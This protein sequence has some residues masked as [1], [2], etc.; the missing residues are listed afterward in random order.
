M[1]GLIVG[2]ILGIFVGIAVALGAHVN[3]DYSSDTGY[4]FSWDSTSGPASLA[5][6]ALGVL[7][8][9]VARR[10][11]DRRL[12]TSAGLLDVAN[13]QPV[14]IGSFF[15]PRNVGCGRDRE[16]DR[17]RAD[18]DRVALCFLPG[19]VVALFT[20][21]TTIVLIDRNLS[22]IDAIKAS[23]DIVK[24]NIG[25]SILAYLIAGLIT[26]VGSSGVRHRN[27][28]R[29]AG[30]GAVPGVHLP[31]AQWRPGR[32]AHALNNRFT[33]GGQAEWTMTSPLRLQQR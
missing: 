1:Y 10:R 21:F 20:M 17:G 32:T 22:P 5:V 8:L 9:I 26:F 4:S 6:S 3:Y 31:Q 27:L 15:K 14:T 11:R 12:H 30:G 24:A 23:I 7:V 28:R 33:L 18:V 13:G 25:Q 19:L 29:A 16:P 2:V